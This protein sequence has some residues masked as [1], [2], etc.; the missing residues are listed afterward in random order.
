MHVSRTGLPMWF[1]VFPF[2]QFIGNGSDKG[3][4]L[5]VDIGSALGHQ[6]IALRQRFP[7]IPGRVVIQDTAQVM[8]AVQPSHDIEP[9]IYD[10]FTPQP[11]KGM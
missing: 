1:D 11:V 9:Q 6:S 3:T 7:N 10:F 5:F 4:I 2:D 8:G